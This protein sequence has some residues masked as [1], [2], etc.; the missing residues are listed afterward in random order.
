MASGSMATKAGRAQ[1]PSVSVAIN[2]NISRDA[3][4][5]AAQKT[6]AQHLLEL[7]RTQQNIA[8]PEIQTE[9]NKAM[10][11]QLQ[12]HVVLVQTEPE[13][14]RQTVLSHQMSQIEEDSD[15]PPPLESGTDDD[16]SSI[17][18]QHGGYDDDEDEDDS[19]PEKNFTL[20]QP[21]H[22]PETNSIQEDVFE[23]KSNEEV[24]VILSEIFKVQKN[25]AV[26]LKMIVTATKSV[27]MRQ[28]KGGV[29]PMHIH[30]EIRLQGQDLENSKPEID[31]AFWPRQLK[32]GLPQALLGFQATWRL[33]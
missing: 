19:D 18:Q 23:G 12:P 3:V 30:G 4:I 5:A 10:V 1:K 32:N 20:H 28:C 25:Q 29:R 22:R 2:E 17:H 7:E 24:Q 11:E 13:K 15:Q 6:N 14:K 8:Q 26:Q 9:A 33:R 21:L 31:E 27:E 16:G